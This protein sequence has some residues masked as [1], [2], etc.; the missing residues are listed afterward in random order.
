MWYTYILRSTLD[1]KL[2]TGATGN[3]QRRLREHS[4]GSSRALLGRGAMELCGY[5]AVKQRHTAFLLEKYLK[6]GSGR[7]FLKKRI[8]P[9]EAQ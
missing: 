4:E 6:T 5:I 1:G 9:D 3:L 2:Y 8:L 7:A